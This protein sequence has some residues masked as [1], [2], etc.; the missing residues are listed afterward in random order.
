MVLSRPCLAGIIVAAVLASEP[1][2]TSAQD[3]TPATREDAVL[4]VDGIVREVFQ[5]ARQGRV[6]Y[7]VQI[8]VKRSES[9]RAPRNPLRVVMPAP[10]DMVYVHASKRQD[11]AVGLADPGAGQPPVLSGVARTVPV[12]RAQV[13][14]YLYPGPNGGWE[15]AG[16]DWFELTAK[17]L[18]DS[19]VGNPAPAAVDRAPGS[20]GPRTNPAPGPARDTKT[21]L[22]GLGLT[23]EA[24]TVQGKFVVRVSSVE[25]GGPSQRAGL[26]PGDIIIGANEKALTGT[27]DLESLAERGGRLNL[28]VLDVNNGK[29]ARVPV[30][31]GASG[32][33]GT[34]GG[35]P[36][37]TD[38][39]EAP[40]ATRDASNPSP[41]SR[42]R[43]LAG[44]FGRAGDSRPAHRNESH[45][46]SSR[47]PR[48]ESWDR[49]RRCHRRGQRRADHRCGIAQRRRAQERRNPIALHPQHAHGQEYSCRSQA[50][51]T[52][53]PVLVAPPR[54]KLLAPLDPA[55]DLAPSRNWCSTTSTRPP[56]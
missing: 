52:R 54:L 18:A 24:K 10:G 31:L 45:R 15:G 21:A 27:E 6:D 13:R 50:W 26:E 44:R 5:S 25:P 14:A 23:G 2:R 42:R 11:T 46:R 43:A 17:A 8:E 53:K 29:T 28:I 36:P 41:P 16:T 34:P 49:S 7:L 32:R 4:S 38:K 37:L 56:R 22:T 20:L 40:V 35:L 1:D 30:E 9:L 55:G 3:R 19:S 39:P 48:P 51:R 33:P 47:Q 12:E